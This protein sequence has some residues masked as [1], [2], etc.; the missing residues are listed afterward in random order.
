[1]KKLFSIVAILS[2][3]FSPVTPAFAA[4]YYWDTNGATPGFGTASGT[5]GTDTYLSTDSTGS[6]A[7]AGPATTTSDAMLFGSGTAGLGAG[8]VTV[9]GTQNSANIVFYALSGEII[10]SGGTINLA[11][12]INITVSNATDTINS[13]ITGANTGLYK[14]D[15]GA[16][17]LNGDITTP[18]EIVANAGALTLAGSNSAATGGVSVNSSGT[19]KLGSATALGT[20][21]FDINGGTIDNSSGGSLTLSTNNVQTWD[22]NFIF[23]G[24][25]DLN[26]GTGAVTLGANRQVT[27]SGGTLTVGGAIGGGACSLTKAGNG[28]LILGGVNTHTGGTHE[29]GGL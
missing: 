14:M 11:N 16:L 5:W 27:V 25:N 18:G 22:G 26:L 21:T 6:S 13:A 4:T 23:T 24:T 15:T 7:T 28:T 1:M 8:T 29:T 9:N 2:L 10:L 19:L 20:G 12:S 3:V 17:I